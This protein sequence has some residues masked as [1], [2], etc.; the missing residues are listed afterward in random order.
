MPAR[1]LP[2]RPNLSQYKKQ[3]KEL[4][5]HRRLQDPTFKLSDAQLAIAREH[6][7]DSWPK[8]AK[9]IDAVLGGAS[10]AA[11]W[12]RAEQA[13]IAGDEAA[14]DGLLREHGG[15]LHNE[16]PK[17]SWLGGL[18]PDYREGDARAIIT[19]TH[20]FSTWEHF[21]AFRETLEEGTGPIARFEAAVDSIVSGELDTVKRLLDED[22]QLV[23]ARSIRTHH[24]TL[25]HYI[26]ANGVEG[27]RQRTPKNAV[28]IATVLLDAGAEVDAM[29]DMYGGSTTLGLVATSEHPKTAGL[30]QP[31][32]ELLLGRGARMDL[33]GTAGHQ[34]GLVRACLA[35]GR[36]EAAEFVAARGAPLDLE[37]AAG[38]GRLDAV[39]RFFDDAG[40]LTADATRKHMEDGYGWACVYGHS[41]VVDFL[42]RCGVGVDTKVRAH[43]EGCTG[44]H[45]GAYHGDPTLVRLL[46]GHGARVD[47]ADDTWQTTPLTWALYAWSEDPTLPLDRYYEVVALLLAAGAAVRS[48]LLEWEKV[49]AD[50]RMQAM[51][52]R[53]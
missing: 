8:F 36:P 46:L 18:S 29:A 52:T 50:S 25:L 14:L 4:V 16:R 48:D 28:E 20:D 1:D 17:S 30:Q 33:P 49:R 53:V 22:P 41:A 10:P 21:A 23:Y 44:L 40:R 6:G 37:S 12:A 13:V 45:L 38:I 39:A 31:L 11:I 32:I 34:D 35:N 3:A 19:D 24:S 5:K 43:G 2:N 7:F 15:M 47:I 27:F 9:H 42:L 51:L 26:G